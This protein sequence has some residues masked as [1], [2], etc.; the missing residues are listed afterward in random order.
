MSAI[1][2]RFQRW[3]L[4]HIFEDGQ[5][6]DSQFAHDPETL[7]AM[8]RAPNTWTAVVDGLPV[9]SGGTLELWPGRH[10]AWAYLSARAQESILLVSRTARDVLRRV[11]GRVECTVRADFPAGQKWA[12]LLGFQIE[13]PCLR[14]FGPQGE[15]H[16]GYVLLNK[17]S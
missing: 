3:H 8:E 4:R 13:T 2:T 12:K 7:R 1:I 17:G 6:E 14:A 16:V 9:A 11:P 10:Q 15:D 5:L